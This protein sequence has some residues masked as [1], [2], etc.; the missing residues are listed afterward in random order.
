M[1]FS[2]QPRQSKAVL[3]TRPQVRYHPAMG[4]HHSHDHSHP[5]GE[6]HHHHH[7]EHVHGVS[8][9]ASSRVLLGVIAINSA[10]VATEFLV[11]LSSGSTAL[12]ADAGHNL[13]DVLGLIVALGA[14]RLAQRPASAKYTYGLGASSILAALL[15]AVLLMVACGALAWEAIHRLAQPTSVASEAVMLVA[16]AGILINGLSAWWLMRTNPHDLNMRGAYLHMAADAAVSLGVVLAGAAM[17]FTGISLIDPA[18]SLV[19]VMVIIGSTWGLLKQSLRLAMGGVPAGLDLSEINAF[20]SGTA[21]VKS[22]SDLHV[23]ALSTSSNALTAHLLVQG[24]RPD[25]AQMEALAREL[26]T[27]FRI[28]HSTLQIHEH[29]APACPLTPASRAV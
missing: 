27:R 19:I 15:N 18:V 12:M 10:F 7:A 13:S 17:Y 23:W 16:G 9:A 24:E 1:P 11:G 28:A 6:G 29:E 4:L 8:G 14:V 2:Q 26:E 20:L 22:V 21:W 3:V 25:D 5:G